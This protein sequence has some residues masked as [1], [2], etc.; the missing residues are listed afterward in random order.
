MKVL[1]AYLLLINFVA[2]IVT[3]YDKR[4]AIRDRWRVSE[5]TLLLISALGGAPMMYLTMRL[6]RH[7]TR[8]MKFMI[9]I[10]VIFFFELIAVLLLLHYVFRLF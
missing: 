8:K 3:I 2:V 9:G 5:F 6:I 1:F 10:P 7:K 4:A